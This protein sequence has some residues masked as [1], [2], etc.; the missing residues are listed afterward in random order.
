[1]SREAVVARAKNKRH[2]HAAD[3]LSSS[4]KEDL[5]GGGARG[6]LPKWDYTRRHLRI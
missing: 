2:K 5:Q 4:S 3:A 1:M 6:I